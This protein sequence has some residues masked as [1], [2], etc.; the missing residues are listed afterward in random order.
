MYVGS[1]ETDETKLFKLEVGYMGA[2]F[3]FI[4]YTLEILQNRSLKNIIVYNSF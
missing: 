4:L 2:H 3:L 1:R